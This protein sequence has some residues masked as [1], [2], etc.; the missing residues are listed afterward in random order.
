MLTEFKRDNTI[1]DLER[2]QEDLA[3][4]KRQVKDYED[5]LRSRIG[6]IR[7]IDAQG[8]DENVSTIIRI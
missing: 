7:H 8:I 6:E 2:L 1:K 3:R 5:Q 4:K